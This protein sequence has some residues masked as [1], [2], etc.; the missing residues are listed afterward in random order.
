MLHIVCRSPYA[1]R[2]LFERLLETLDASATVLLTEDGVLGASGSCA[3]RLAES[4]ARCCV[5]REDLAARG[6]LERCHD[7]LE[8][9]DMGIFVE[10]TACHSSS[11]SWY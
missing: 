6:L 7:A 8:V 10:L 9:V 3:A 1:D 4:P 11:L 2:A 5:L